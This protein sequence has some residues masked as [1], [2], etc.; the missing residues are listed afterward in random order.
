MIDISIKETQDG[1]FLW[2]LSEHPIYKCNTKRC[3]TTR[4]LVYSLYASARTRDDIEELR[5]AAIK[6]GIRLL[7]EEYTNSHK[8]SL[9]GMCQVIH[10]PFKQWHGEELKE[11]CWC[12]KVLSVGDVLLL[13][14]HGFNP[15]TSGSN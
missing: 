8:L 7:S 12:K 3:K 9:W 13:F 5:Q 14:L 6:H 4:K 10:P 1:F 2:T 11:G 15:T